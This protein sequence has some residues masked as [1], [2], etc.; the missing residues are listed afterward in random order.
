MSGEERDRRLLEAWDEFGDALKRAAR[1]IVRPGVPD[2]DID[3]AEGIRHVA[4]TITRALEDALEAGDTDR[5]MLHRL[6]TPW[7]KSGADNPDGLYTGCAIDG[8]A[9]YRITGERGTAKVLSFTVTRG[10]DAVQRGEPGL[11]GSL[12][13]HD[14]HVEPDGTFEVLLVGSSASDAD[15]SSCRNRIQLT[16]DSASLMIRQFFEDWEAEVPGTMLIERLPSPAAPPP[17]LTTDAVVDALRRVGERCETTLT[18]WADL[19][20]RQ[21]PLRNVVRPLPSGQRKRRQAIPGGGG[22][23]GYFDLAPEEA[24]LV[25]FAPPVCAYWNMQIGSYWHESFDYRNV[26]C[27]INAA[28]AVVDADGVVHVVIAARDA[29]WANWLDT[30][31]HREGSIGMRWWQASHV[32]KVHCEVVRLDELPER[33]ALTVAR[34]TPEQRHADQASRRRAVDRRFRA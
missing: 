28:Q 13:D 9:N 3:R 18:F 32:P 16:A 4:R 14:L 10:P 25:E 27:S 34:V 29:G 23:L 7:N 24:L 2:T 20:E 31:G 22:C 5:P 17:Q 21:K 11:I 12:F 19:Q 30:A 15:A 33:L 26:R 1:V 8:T 6:I